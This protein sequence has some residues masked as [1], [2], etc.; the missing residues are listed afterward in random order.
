M[1]EV[2]KGHFVACHHLK[3][4]EEMRERSTLIQTWEANA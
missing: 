4:V 1:V 3:R 2:E